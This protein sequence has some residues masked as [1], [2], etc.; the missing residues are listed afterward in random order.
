MHSFLSC[1]EVLSYGC[2]WFDYIFFPRSFTQKLKVTKQL[3]S[4]HTMFPWVWIWLAWWVFLFINNQD[5]GAEHASG[6][7]QLSPCSFV[8]YSEDPS[9]KSALD[10]EQKEIKMF[11]VSEWCTF[12]LPCLAVLSCKTLGLA[13]SFLVLT[14]VRKSTKIELLILNACIFTHGRGGIAWV[15]ER[16]ALSLHVYCSVWHCS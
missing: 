9:P 7:L 16:A 15:Y 11:F 14:F 6:N 1:S 3:N 13:L 2:N 4:S 8:K 10:M 5:T 12:P